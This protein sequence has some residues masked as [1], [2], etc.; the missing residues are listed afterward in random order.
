MSFLHPEI[1]YFL[2]AL[3]IPVIIHFVSFRRRRTVYFSNNALLKEVYKEK[4]RVKRLRELI[5]LILRMCF[6]AALVLA[7]A[8]PR[9]KNDSDKA[10]SSSDLVAVYV[11]NSMSMGQENVTTRLVDAARAQAAGIVAE[12]GRTHRF[13]LLTNSREVEN[14][15]PMSCDEMLLRLDAMKCEGPSGTFAEVMENLGVIKER[16]GFES[17]VLFVISDFQKNF[18]AS[19][20]KSDSTISVVPLYVAS[21][22]P[23][24]VFIDT[25]F[26][27]SPLVISG[28]ANEL[29]VEVV[30]AAARDLTAFPVEMYIDGEEAALV[31]VDVARGSKSKVVVPF[32]INEEGRHEITVSIHDE[33]VTFDDNYYAVVNVRDKVRVVEIGSDDGGHDLRDVFGDELFDFV[34]INMRKADYHFIKDFDLAVVSG[35]SPISV[36]L[37]NDLMDFVSDGGTLAVNA[38][39]VSDE[40]IIIDNLKINL[41]DATDNDTVRLS[42][43]FRSNIFFKDVII[44]IPS[45]V[46]FPQVYRHRAMTLRESS[47]ANVLLMLQNGR[48]WLLS[49][50]YNDG[51]IFVF[52]SSFEAES[53]N[54]FDN[55][56]CVP[57]FVRMAAF[58]G[59]GTQLAQTIGRDE[60]VA[61]FATTVSDGDT[62]LTAWNDNRIESEMTFLS[63]VDIQDFMRRNGVV[64]QSVVRDALSAAAMHRESTLWKLFAL[65]A[66]V[67]FVAETI[68]VLIPT[69]ASRSQKPYPRR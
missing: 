34:S 12:M 3:M 56:L 63:D 64:S 65:L 55:A 59:K 67:F 6:I 23:E 52:A 9:L 60:A 44:D 41:S 35:A 62:L 19:D 45:N 51:N 24:N 28:H 46:D 32:V 47:R 53:T 69:S 2:F 48:P 20:V 27:A 4:A 58:G 14:E 49:S 38:P 7:F 17:A 22:T 39:S 31:N 43:V 30:N 26:L 66:A 21:N 13:V 61:G 57:I 36:S 50:P 29:T 16:N 42:D 18:L 68:F 54:F 8:R 11:D 40:K 1:L 33:P 37:Q 15:H 10:I 25:V 5:I